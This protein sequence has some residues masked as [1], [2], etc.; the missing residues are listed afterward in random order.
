MNSGQSATV[1]QFTVTLYYNTPWFPKSGEHGD[2]EVGKGVEG[3]DNGRD[4]DEADG[5]QSH[6]LSKGRSS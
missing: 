6:N 5:D 2:L 3:E 4:D 1:V